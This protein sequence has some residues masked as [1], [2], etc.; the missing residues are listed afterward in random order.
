MSSSPAVALHISTG[1][2]T[3]LEGRKPGGR[4]K[5]TLLVSLVLAEMAPLKWTIPEMSATAG[6]AEPE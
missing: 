2:L 6:L 4:T 3:N 1:T 5:G